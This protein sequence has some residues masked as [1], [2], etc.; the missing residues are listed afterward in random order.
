MDAPTNDELATAYAFSNQAPHQLP[1]M[2]AGAECWRCALKESGQGP[3]M[4]TVPPEPHR[5]GVLVVAEAPGGTE[6]QTGTPLVGASGKEVRQALRAG[7]HDPTTTAYTNAILCR[8]PDDLKKFLTQIKRSKAQGFENPIECCRPRLLREVKRSDYAILMGSASLT[9]VG[10]NKSITKLRGTPVQIPDGPPAMPILHAAFVMRDAGKRFRHVFRYDVAKAIRFSRG[11][12]T[13]KDPPYFIVE[14]AQQLEQFLG[15]TS[16]WWAVDTETDGVDPWSCNI[17]RIGIGTPTAVAIFRPLSV[18]GHRLMDMAEIEACVSVFNRFFTSVQVPLIFHNWFGF[19]SVLLARHGF[20][21]P[22]EKVKDTLIGHHVGSSSELPHGLDFLGS[23]YT[24]APYWKDDVKHAHVK[25]DEVLDKYLSYDIA[26]THI[27]APYVLNNVTA[28]QQDHIYAIDMHMGA[29]GRSMSRLGIYIDKKKQFAFAE[30]Y[31]TKAERLKAEFYEA[32]GREI[33]P[34]SPTQL[35]SLLFHDL[36]LPIL[37][38]FE[39]A[40]G[41]ASTAEPV[42]L[43]LLEMGIGVREQKVIKSLLGWREADKV[44]STYTGRIVDGKI[45]GGPPA[46]GDGRL[47]TTWKTYGAVT[48][49]WSSGD[50]VNLQNII[51]KLRAMYVPAPGNVFVAADASALELR[52]STLLANDDILV[53]AFANF[54]AG[55]GP[56]IH[57]VNG[58]TVF[59]CKPE[60]VTEEPRTFAKRFVYG[61]TYGAGPPKIFQTLSLLRDDELRPVFPNISLQEI[62]KVYKIWWDAH[63][64]IVQWQKDL[65]SSWRKCGYIESAFHKRRRYF[66]GGEDPEQMKNFPVQSTAADIQNDAVAMIVQRYP[67]NY[68]KNRG[69][70]LQVHDQTVVECGEDEVDHV[71]RIIQESMQRRVGRMFFPAEAKSGLNWKAVS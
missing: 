32:C 5:I 25:T 12:S 65:I 14:S 44:L 9:A 54:D 33:N 35:R 17:R 68:E 39:T 41:E 60:E 52:I 27:E 31:Q 48:G 30:E 43:A 56:D 49:R 67:F 66:I 50:P 59:K 55:T 45:E 64:K 71:K 69:L 46:H 38:E 15:Q 7:G 20:T 62:E 3:V 23:I 18:Q 22:D 51:K 24:D 29:V 37:E 70:V 6:V 47:R 26:V 40:S 8:P 34:G 58:A 28:C 16:N 53:E 21:I 4:P 13:W 1:A 57:K 42:L 2:Q 11:G 10:I 61:L 19:D 63:P 36:K